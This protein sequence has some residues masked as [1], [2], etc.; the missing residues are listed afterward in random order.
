MV[1]PKRIATLLRAISRAGA[2]AGQS[3]ADMF[4]LPSDISHAALVRFRR[5]RARE[6]QPSMV[7]PLTPAFAPAGGGGNTY[8]FNFPG[9]PI[10][11]EFELRRWAEQVAG[12]MSRNERGR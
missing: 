4:N 7:A 11:S 3:F 9:R 1:L 10:V 12:A 5:Q 6:L 2:T 8:V